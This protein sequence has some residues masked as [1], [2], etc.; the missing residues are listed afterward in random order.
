MKNFIKY[1][2]EVEE[3][4]LAFR[5]E[6]LPKRVH[7]IFAS[8][9]AKENEINN[10]DCYRMGVDLGQSLVA[11]NILHLQRLFYKDSIKNSSIM[12]DFLT[13][14][15]KYPI[16]KNCRGCST[17][18]LAYKILEPIYMRLLEKMTMVANQNLKFT[19]SLHAPLEKYSGCTDEKLWWLDYGLMMGIRNFAERELILLRSV[20]FRKKK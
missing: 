14:T 15:G 13:E 9:E 17:E 12:Q 2:Q 6:Q 16:E 8:L 1:L 18:E 5:A 4:A 19:F 3:G 10:E 20:D 7:T 11:N